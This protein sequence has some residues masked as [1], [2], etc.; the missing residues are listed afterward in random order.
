M[1]SPYF[2]DDLL[3]RLPSRRLRRR[4]TQTM[5][6]PSLHQPVRG[7]LADAGAGADDHD[8]LPI[9]LLLGRHA[10]QLGLFERP[11]LDVEG[12]L[13]VH[14][15]VLVDGLG[16]AHDLD[17]AVVELGGHARFALVLAPGDH[18]QPG[19]QHD[20]RIRVAHGRRVGPLAASRS[21]P[22]SPCGTAPA[23]PAIA[24]FSASTSPVAGSQSTNSGL[25]FVR[26]K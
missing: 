16:A 23:R 12:L 19:N 9:E 7:G 3:R 4:S 20:R 8:D 11:V 21:R 2:C 26:R 14:R 22:R 24:D 18:A 6:A 10:S 17:G 1:P 25:I 13:L 5:C 15:L